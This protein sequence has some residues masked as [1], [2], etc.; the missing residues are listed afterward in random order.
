MFCL[1][2]TVGCVIKYWLRERLRGLVSG[3]HPACSQHRKE[4][5]SVWAPKPMLSSQHHSK[6]RELSMWHANMHKHTHSE[7]DYV[8]MIVNLPLSHL[9]VTGRRLPKLSLNLSLSNCCGQWKLC[10]CVC[11]CVSIFAYERGGDCLCICT[12][13]SVCKCVCVSLQAADGTSC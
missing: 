2:L 11:V 5:P 12:Q 6:Y 8:S 7:Q 9:A 3:E 13:T 10:M 1:C 4:Q